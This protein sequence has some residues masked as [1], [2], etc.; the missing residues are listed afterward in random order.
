MIKIINEVRK[1]IKNKTYLS[2]L[3]L[4]LTIPDICSQVETGKEDS[5]RG[6]Y[7]DWFNKHIDKEAFDLGIGEF[8]EQTFNGN[9]CYALRCKVLHNGNVELKQTS[10]NLK[11]ELDHFQFTIPESPEYYYGYKYV[12]LPGEDEAIKTV[13]I[14]AIDYLCAIICEAAEN[15][16][17][18]WGAKK[19]SLNIKSILFKS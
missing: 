9:M 15:F 6:I 4:A 19:T 1:A 13:T 10:R 16:Y 14:I 18:N 7:I 3:T 12:Y 17:N 8:K 2:A 5:V 11:I